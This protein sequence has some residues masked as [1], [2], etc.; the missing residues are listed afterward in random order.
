MEVIEAQELVC[1]PDTSVQVMLVALKLVMAVAKAFPTVY[2]ERAV[3]ALAVVLAARRATDQVGFRQ[4][5]VD[6]IKLV[7]VL[8]GEYSV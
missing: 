3:D 4:V 1:R 8:L 2:D 7:S 6:A 5:W